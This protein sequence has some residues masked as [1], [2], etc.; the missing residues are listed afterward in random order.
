MT[1][2]K[3]EIPNQNYL[4]ET[5]QELHSDIRKQINLMFTSSSQATFLEE[6]IDE[7]THKLSQDFLSIIDANTDINIDL[8][9]KNF[10]DS[11]IPVQ[12]TNFASY[13]KYLDK[14]VVSHSI[15][16]SSPQF[17]GHMTSALPCF[18]RPLRTTHDSNECK[19]QSK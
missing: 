9:L 15:H 13:L 19:M 14:N 17:I 3:Q 18:V 5:K 16:T 10:S 6:Q 7:I 4:F 1:L 8:L 12:P 11:Q 2:S